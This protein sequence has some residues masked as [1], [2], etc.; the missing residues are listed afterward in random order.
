M[1]GFHP[2][3]ISPLN[4]WRVTMIMIMKMTTKMKM[5]MRMTMTTMTK[6]RRSELVQRFYPIAI[7]LLMIS[8]GGLCTGHPLSQDERN[9]IS[10]LITK[11]GKT[12]FLSIKQVGPICCGV[13]LS[14]I[15][16]RRLTRPELFFKPKPH[17]PQFWE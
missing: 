1:S 3:A 8:L 15:S 14:R 9:S 11:K 4:A 2:I 7:S 13:I 12:F 10:P 17:L 16:G 6:R 5:T